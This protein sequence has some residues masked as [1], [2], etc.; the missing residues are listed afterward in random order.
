MELISPY[1]LLYLPLAVL[2]FLLAR[3]RDDRRRQSVGN[4]FL[5]RHEAPPDAVRLAAARPRRSWLAILQA[6]FLIVLIAALARP[7]ATT[8]ATRVTFVFDVS[9]SMGARD[10][11]G[12]R[13]DLARA[14]ALALIDELPASSRVRIV[15]ARATPDDSGEFS[16]RDPGLRQRI[17]AIHPTAGS[18]AVEDAIETGRAGAGTDAVIFVFSDAPPPD[19]RPDLRANWIRVGG[20]AEN[21]AITAL[22][23]RRL[24]LAPANCQVL[25]E[26]RNFGASARDTRVEIAR[27]GSALSARP[28]HIAAGATV[29][30][31]ADVG[32]IDGVITAA[33][34]SDD[35]LRV[36]N[37][38]FTVTPPVDRIRALL[39]TRGNFFLE[40]VL[41]ARP[42]LALDV[43]APGWP[44][45][46]QSRDVIICDG[47]RDLPPGDA[48]VL[49]IA[50]SGAPPAARGAELALVDRDHPVARSLDVAGIAADAL[51]E[52]TRTGAAVILRAGRFPVVTAY[53]RDGRRVVEWS[54]D[55]A[56]S[57]LP[58]STAFPVLVAN[59]VDWLAVR[60]ESPGEVVAGEPL[61]WAVA[62]PRLLSG[63]TVAGPD[64]QPVPFRVSGRQLAVGVTDA[65][66]AYRVRGPEIDRTFVVNPAT[67]TES[68]LLGPAIGAAPSPS[69]EP[70]QLSSGMARR[71]MSTPLL[72]AAIGLFALEWRYA[73]RRGLRR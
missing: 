7:L 13:L 29:A 72:L 2:V 31:L 73:S 3:R 44:F 25:V 26:V 46:G 53:E 66:G 65:P 70:P 30:F 6:A 51:P 56:A 62:A 15:T 63:V 67:E 36:D 54:L 16:A 28:L 10:G 58:F 41:A 45:D 22:A 5:W 64:G 17:A 9:A 57:N 11:A 4:L 35:A 19:V 23:V 71:E 24:P 21:I 33:L 48:G 50:P 68:D 12:T 1:A 40:R 34:S 20:A 47:C 61:R 18:V 52:I 49:L 55:L 37:L 59:A 69:A 27:N 39:V 42:G 8:R 43:R 60:G 32:S 38:R 14:R